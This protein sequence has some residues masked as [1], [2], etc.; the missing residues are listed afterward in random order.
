M[1]HSSLRRTLIKFAPLSLALPNASGATTP[2]SSS[3]SPIF[4]TQ[5]PDLVRE[6]VTVAHFNLKRVRE[7]VEAR[8]ALAKASWDWGFGDWETALGA[9]SH[10]GNR[11]IALY[12][13]GKG[14][15]PTLFSATMLG[16]LDVVKALVAAHP[17][18]QRVT[19]PH[20]IS[21]L[22]HAKAGGSSAQEVL[23]YLEALG[24]AD[25]KPSVPITEQE[26]TAIAGSYAFGVGPTERIDISVNKGQL[27]FTRAG[28][29][30]RRLFPLSDR[31]FYPAG[32]S[33]VQIR[34]AGDAPNMS[35][36]VHDPDLVLTA[37]RQGSK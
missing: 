15:P 28:T 11:E 7:L 34:F 26:M 4:P 32:S 24:G 29:T 20:S 14:A 10:V 18:V 22:S 3:I 31:A 27:L 2:D 33:A 17:E 23:K 19:G 30:A 36:S 8:P 5:S 21:L 9:A 13:L 35:L 37:R 25:G 6:M 12:L 16:Q 1:K